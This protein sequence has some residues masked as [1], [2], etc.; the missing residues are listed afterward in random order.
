MVGRPS[1][2]AFAIALNEHL[3]WYCIYHKDLSLVA[4]ISS[5]LLVYMDPLY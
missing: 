4:T 1:Y 5:G 3:R 2:L